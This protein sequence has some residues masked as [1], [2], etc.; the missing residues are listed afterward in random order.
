MDLDRL[1]IGAGVDPDE[2]TAIR[3]VEAENKQ[4][5]E[6]IERFKTSHN[7][8]VGTQINGILNEIL[9]NNPMVD[10]VMIVTGDGLPI[11]EAASR[12]DGDVLGALVSLFAAVANR[13]MCEQVVSSIDE[14]SIR[15]RSGDRFIVRVFPDFDPPIYLLILSR[16][17]FS[18]RRVTYQTIKQCS[19]L[20]SRTRTNMNGKDQ[21]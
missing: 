1:H 14:M 3:D 10:G 6:T 15:G 17:Q 16:G 4:R 12:S 7:T 19:V 13:I 21:T 18:Y 20:L 5:I 2:L 9:E 8:P 11:A